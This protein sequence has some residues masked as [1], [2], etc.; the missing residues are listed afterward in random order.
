MSDSLWDRLKFSRRNWKSSEETRKKANARI[1]GKKSEIYLQGH[2]MA[3]AHKHPKPVPLSADIEQR[4]KAA[5]SKYGEMKG[6]VEG[7]KALEGMKRQ[8][9]APGWVDRSMVGNM[10]P[11]PDTEKADPGAVLAR[12]Q[13]DEKAKARKEEEKRRRAAGT[14]PTPKAPKEKVNEMIEESKKTDAAIARGK[15]VAKAF[16]GHKVKGREKILQQVLTTAKAK[17]APKKAAAP[18]PKKEAPAP[19]P[20]PAQ[21]TPGKSYF[22]KTKG[23]TVE[24][25]GRAMVMG[26]SPAAKP[27]EPARELSP[28]EQKMRRIA[29]ELGPTPLGKTEHPFWD[30]AQHHRRFPHKDNW[31]GLDAAM[32]KINMEHEEALLAAKSGETRRERRRA[33]RA[34]NH[35]REAKVRIAT[36]V[37]HSYSRK[38]KVEKKKGLMSRLKGMFGEGY[39][40]AQGHRLMVLRAIASDQ[41]VKEAWGKPGEDAPKKGYSGQKTNPH[42]RS[43]TPTGMMR[44]VDKEGEGLEKVAQDKKRKDNR[45]KHAAKSLQKTREVM[46]KLK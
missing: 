30:Y 41:V 29:K 40:P 17:K 16:Q 21:Q 35:D 2:R 6:E 18:A 34:A 45:R 38:P 39:N 27:A 33:L 1:H 14:W 42:R 10:T 8:P 37:E 28:L 12:I 44:V 3:Q 43:A 24:K 23:P 22:R 15:A 25:Q 7:A 5:K 11:H 46:A 9:R 26:V 36:A 32:H 4:E 31:I 13:R 20:A 19:A